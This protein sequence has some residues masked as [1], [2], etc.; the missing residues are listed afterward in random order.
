[1]TADPAVT[2]LLEVC[3]TWAF[4]SV[5]VT[6]AVSAAGPTPGDHP[7]VRVAVGGPRLDAPFEYVRSLVGSMSA[8]HAA[9]TIFDD[10]QNYLDE[11]ELYGVPVPPCDAHPGHPA[12]L[13]A[14]GMTVRLRCSVEP[15]SWFE[16]FPGQLDVGVVAQQ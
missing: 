13:D 4:R 15:G 9:A 3:L 6:V 2:A 1:M 14:H 12:N 16:D 7:D 5:G 11:G 10:V 8:S